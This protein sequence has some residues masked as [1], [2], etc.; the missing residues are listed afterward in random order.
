[1]PQTPLSLKNPPADDYDRSAW[2]AFYE[3]NP[4]M[5]RSAG[6]EATADAASDGTSGDGGEGSTPDQGGADGGAAASDT[7]PDYSFIPE[8]FR[9]DDKPDPTAFRTAY[10][11]LAAF[12]A[13]TEEARGELPENAD[14][15]KFEIPED[16]EVPE[17]LAVAIDENDPDL[18]VIKDW[19]HQHGVNQAA[20]S[21]LARIMA[22][23]ELRSQAQAMETYQ[24]EMKA[25]GAD[26][27]SRIDTITRS[28]SS[29]LPADQA[30][31]LTGAAFSAN[32][33]KALEKLLSGPG[34]RASTPT[35][36]VD[37]SKMTPLQKINLANQQ[38]AKDGYRRRPN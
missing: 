8:Q 31:A 26:A 6:A 22:G 5:R 38:A 9:T 28:L 34:G 16:F 35:T 37:T 2:L 36:T 7:P 29:R 24:T 14:G 15:Y 27:Q 18:P 12:K 30:E 20:V 13:Q 32:A 1:M 33:V 10:D 11:E 4:D 3:A 25:L 17:G 23:R 21:E 19:A